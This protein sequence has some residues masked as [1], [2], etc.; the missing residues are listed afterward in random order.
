MSALI[1]AVK[2]GYKN[3]LL[4]LIGGGA[5]VNIIDQVYNL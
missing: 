3:I 4:Y 2:Y 5:D 1:I